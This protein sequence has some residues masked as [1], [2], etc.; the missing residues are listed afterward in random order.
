MAAGT[1]LSFPCVGVASSQNARHRIP[2]RSPSNSHS[3]HPCVNTEAAPLDGQSSSTISGDEQPSMHRS[4]YNTFS[5]TPAHPTSTGAIMPPYTAT[6]SSV[7]VS[8][9]SPSHS[10]ELSSIATYIFGG[11]PS[12]RTLGHIHYNVVDRK[13]ESSYRSATS[14][15]ISSSCTWKALM[16]FSVVFGIFA[17][18]QQAAPNVVYMAPEWQWDHNIYIPHNDGS[19][20]APSTST[21][22]SGKNDNPNDSKMSFLPEPTE[23]RRITLM[24]QTVSSRPLR[25]LTD[26]SS[27]PNRAYARQWMMDYTLYDSGRSPSNTKSCFDKI[28]LLNTILDKQDSESKHNNNEPPHMWPFT[29][30]VNYDALII[31]PPDSIVTELDTNFLDTFLPS[32]K[33]VA[34]AGWSSSND[35]DDSVTPGG[36]KNKLNSA[37]DIVIFNLRHKHVDA[38]AKVW[39]E[40]ALPRQVTCGAHNDLGMLV[41]AIASVMDSGEDLSD[42]IEPIPESDDGRGFVGRDHLIKCIPPSVPESRS[43]MLMKS[44]SE[45]QTTLQETAD[46]VCYRFYPKCEVIT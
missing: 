37:S 7:S 22:A 14:L 45:Y 16:V 12:S 2:R 29:P 11:R 33:L 13:F 32:D 3:S 44:L 8:S 46:A 1:R 43:T 23:I 9:S 34:I 36:R 40:L 15:A 24:A 4:N 28:F 19:I 21:T 18:I 41:T 20:P 17:C 30:R 35:I 6:R 26:I 39:W 25:R 38:V 27:R 42:L 31:L 10:S 5:S